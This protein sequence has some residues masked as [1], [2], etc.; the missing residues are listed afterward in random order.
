MVRAL[1]RS[2]HQDPAAIVGTDAP[3]HGYYFRLV[4]A[5]RGKPA[6]FVAYP[7]EYR[8]SGV[9]TFIVAPDGVVYERGLGPD[10]AKAAGALKSTKP[11]SKWLAVD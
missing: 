7:A 8:S 6:S 9:M 11:D 10:T 2:E 1:A 4:A 5:G 3:F